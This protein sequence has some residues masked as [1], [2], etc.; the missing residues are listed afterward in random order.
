[1]NVNIIVM[2]ISLFIVY[3]CSITLIVTAYS[4][5]NKM[6]QIITVFD[7]FNDKMKDLKS[8]YKNI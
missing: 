2:Y 8:A 7:R 1:M 3:V 6:K 5:L 4:I